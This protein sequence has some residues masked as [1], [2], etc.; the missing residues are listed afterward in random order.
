MFKN[1]ESKSRS[2]ER[3][4]PEVEVKWP[5]KSRKQQVVEHTLGFLLVF[6]SIVWSAV[7]GFVYGVV[8]QYT[9]NGISVATTAAAVVL[10]LAFAVAAGVRW[11]QLW[12]SG[13]R[14]V[15]H[16]EFDVF[17][18]RPQL[19]NAIFAVLWSPM[20][21]LVWLP[22]ALLGSLMYGWIGAVILS[23]IVGVAVT[24]VIARGIRVRNQQKIIVMNTL[25]EQR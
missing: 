1:S 6:G 17:A 25:K 20:C 18:F 13:H 14:L 11:L 10:P 4:V 23:V 7:V 15:Y 19:S 8:T 24:V 3:Y 22:F 2:I 21:A 5:C 9:G 16:G 12:L